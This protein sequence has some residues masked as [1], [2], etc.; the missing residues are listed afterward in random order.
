M[1]FSAFDKISYGLYV[2]SAP[3]EGRAV[4]CVV[5]TFAQV[6]AQPPRVTVAIHK[7]NCTAAA[8]QK[9]GVFAVSVLDES[10]S[11]ELIGLFGFCSSLQ[12]DK[13]A[14]LGAADKGVDENGAPYLRAH[15]ASRFACK[16][17]GC[18]DV[19]THFLFLAEPTV[20]ETL[21]SVPPLT[22]ADYHAVKKGLTPPRA[23]SYRPA[24]ASAPGGKKRWRCKVCG[25]IYEVDALP[26][27]FVCPVCGQGAAVFEPV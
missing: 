18:F 10:A 1:D 19:G 23:S 20:W 11:M 26:E 15:A 25:Y 22:Y 5:N 21:N 13:F 12:V 4:G 3:G 9:A 24:D 16:V 2:V 17:I 27:D 7:D 6:T 14:A 8:I